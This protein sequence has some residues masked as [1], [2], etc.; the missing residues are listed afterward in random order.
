MATTHKLLVLVR[1]TKKN[2][3]HVFHLDVKGVFFTGEQSVTHSEEEGEL[4][5]VK[6]NPKKLGLQALLLHD[7]VVISCFHFLH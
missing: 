6:S 7:V 3:V 5:A 2:T 4:P 1:R